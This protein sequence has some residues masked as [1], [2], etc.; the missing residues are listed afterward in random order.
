MKALLLV[1]VASSVASAHPIGRDD[2]EI[3]RDPDPVLIVEPPPPPR[4][5]RSPAEKLH[6]RIGLRYGGG[7]QPIEHRTITSMGV[8][9]LTGDISISDHVR[10]FADYELLLLDADVPFATEL[11]GFGHR[12]S[13]GLLRELAAKRTSD[14][15]ARFDVSAEIGGGAMLTPSAVAQRVIPHGLVGLRCGFSLH[16]KHEERLEPS[17]GFEL[18]VRAIVVPEGIGLTFGLGLQW[19]E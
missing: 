12:G 8:F 15:V 6:T 2:V 18:L 7:K 17:F 14:R 16:T 10:M 4:P 13:L 9:Q 1:M 11:D 19:G 3:A 5:P